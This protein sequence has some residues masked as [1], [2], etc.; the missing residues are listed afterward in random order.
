L[1]FRDVVKRKAILTNESI[2]PL[3]FS[4]PVDTDE[5]TASVTITDA[6]VLVNGVVVLCTSNGCAFAFDTDM[7]VWSRIVDAWY[8]T[9]EFYTPVTGLLGQQATGGPLAMA[10][11]TC[12]CT[13]TQAGRA[14]AGEALQSDRELHKL[15]VTSHLEVSQC[16][17]H[18]RSK[19]SL[20]SFSHKWQVLIF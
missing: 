1:Y 16:Y 3:L 5:P 8:A 12:E 15:L 20:I 2:S 17:I 6:R 4:E 14:M 10:Q 9:S 13:R 11:A 19:P 18:T 7:G